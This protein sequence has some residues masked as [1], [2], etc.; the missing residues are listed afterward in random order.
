MQGQLG[1]SSQLLDPRQGARGRSLDSYNPTEITSLIGKSGATSSKGA[2]QQQYTQL[3]RQLPLEMQNPKYWTKSESPERSGPLDDTVE[4]KPRWKFDG[5]V[6]NRD[7]PEYGNQARQDFQ[8]RQTTQAPSAVPATGDTGS[9]D[10]GG[11]TVGPGSNT[12]QPEMPDTSATGSLV[13]ALGGTGVQDVASA[14]APVQ[15]QQAVD[16]RRQ[17]MIDAVARQQGRAVPESKAAP[18][19]QPVQQFAAQASKAA[20]VS[21]QKAAAPIK[22]AD[23]AAIENWKKLPI[24]DQI[25]AKERY[26]QYVDALPAGSTNIG[27]Y[28]GRKVH[29][30]NDG[31]ILKERGDG[32]LEAFHP[33]SSL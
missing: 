20:Q 16:P 33:Y 26:G 14:A 2:T 18:V 32:R 29:V 28:N 5:L 25:A 7:F 23:T 17:Q 21:E 19:T 11:L 6:F 12:G 13:D 10:T 1:Q 8:A 4:F 24:R 15:Q 3:L 30:T 9:T 22:T 27:T 31:V